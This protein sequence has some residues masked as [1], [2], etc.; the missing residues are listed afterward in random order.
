MSP[1][2]NQSTESMTQFG[3]RDE[4]LNRSSEVRG[5]K[6]KVCTAILPNLTLNFSLKINVNYCFY[7][8]ASQV[9]EESLSQVFSHT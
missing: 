9:G 1:R 6:M 3:S 4:N 7:R 8:I 2:K 5:S